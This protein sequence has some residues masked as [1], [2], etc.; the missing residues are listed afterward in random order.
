MIATY[1][2][3]VEFRN[4]IFCNSNSAYHSWNVDNPGLQSFSTDRNL[5]HN[6]ARHADYTG[7]PVSFSSMQRTYGQDANSINGRNPL[8][9]NATAGNFRLQI[10]SPALA[11]GLDVLD[12]NNNGST[13]DTIP[14]G[15]YITGT[16]VIGLLPQSP[17]PQ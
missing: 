15:A 6:Q 14:A 4:N 16:E 7:G 3:D 2:R 8:F 1:M 11:L 10:G 17:V 9:V 5:Y 13:V 12:L